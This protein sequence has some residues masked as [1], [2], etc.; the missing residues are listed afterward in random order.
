MVQSETRPAFPVPAG[1]LTLDRIGDLRAVFGEDV[2][3]LIG[4]AVYE[5]SPDLVAN[6]A[7]FRFLASGGEAA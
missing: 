7:H 6:A 1:G 5:R 2:A 4:S 3:F